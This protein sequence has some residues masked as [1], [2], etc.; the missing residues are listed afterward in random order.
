MCGGHSAITVW[1]PPPK[2]WLE[3]KTCAAM[4]A[5]RGYEEIITHINGA[6]CTK[7]ITCRSKMAWRA[8]KGDWLGG[9]LFFVVVIVLEIE[10][11]WGFLPMV[12]LPAPKVKAPF[13][14]IS[15]P[16]CRAERKKKGKG[17]KMVSEHQKLESDFL[18]H[19]VILMYS[20]LRPPLTNSLP[21]NSN[22][23][24]FS[25]KLR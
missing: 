4:Y 12:E 13:F 16:T 8:G 7:Q 25:P 22:C 9:F 15:L 11:S 2:I 24:K 18:L 17:L 21:Q 23:R 14:F 20:L 19:K 10:P 1:T 6:F 3:V 5:P